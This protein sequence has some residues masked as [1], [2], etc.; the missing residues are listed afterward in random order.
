VDTVELVAG[1]DIRGF[2]TA[3]FPDARFADT[4]DI[5]Q[6]GF[7]SSLFAMQLVLFLER[8]FAIQI[9][10]EQLSLDNLRSVAAMTG[11]VAGCRRAAGAC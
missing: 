8:H 9:P 10:N 5:F 7:V 4:D 6:L 1:T 11:L 2:I 3:G